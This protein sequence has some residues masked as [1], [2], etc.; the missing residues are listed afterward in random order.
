MTV[1]PEPPPGDRGAE[2]ARGRGA[3]QPSDT[4]VD[5]AFA[6]IVSEWDG[7]EPSWP[8]GSP[9]RRGPLPLGTGRP[10]PQPPPEPSPPPTTAQPPADQPAQPDLVAPQP[11]PDDT[12]QDAT[13][14]QADADEGHYEP[15]EPPPVPALHR[16]TVGALALIVLGVVLL[17]VPGVVGLGS[18]VGFPL[19]LLSVTGGL[20]WL[21][22]RLRTGPPTDSGWD[23]GAQV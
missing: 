4:E 17:L 23:D 3:H 14:E 2:S 11:V 10:A 21:L 22:A 6:Q 7:A 20:A 9:P 12:P 16:A 18:P 15:P 19:G 1:P 8:G 5:A 13:A